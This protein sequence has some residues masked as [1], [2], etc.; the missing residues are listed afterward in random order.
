VSDVLARV[1]SV[2]IEAP[3]AAPRPLPTVACAPPGVDRIAVLG[4][5]EAVLPAGAAL[6][7]AA[8]RAARAKSGLLASWGALSRSPRAPAGPGAARTCAALRGRGL[9][10]SAGGRLVHLELPAEAVQAA[11]ALLRAAAAA[12]TPTV[13]ALA[14]PRTDELDRLLAEQDLLVVLSPGEGSR[15]G[16]LAAESL[17][18]LRRPVVVCAAAPSRLA[19]AL[20]L[21]GLAGGALCRPA[22]A[23][24]LEALR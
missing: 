1:R 15:V 7:L 21:A 14:G 18:E 12:R 11:A 8:A 6:A 2:F 10:A 22:L 20:S 5:R 9:E 24:A 16:R 23:P 19:G 13:L 4:P 17:G 3:A